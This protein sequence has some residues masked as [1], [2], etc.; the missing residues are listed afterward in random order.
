VPYGNRGQTAKRNIQGGSKKVSCCTV[1][2]AYFFEP[3]CKL[4]TEKD[5]ALFPYLEFGFGK[6][7]LTQHCFSSFQ[8]V[9]VTY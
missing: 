2:T 7:P 3:P 5:R 4:L 6:S 8:H 1:S 9:T